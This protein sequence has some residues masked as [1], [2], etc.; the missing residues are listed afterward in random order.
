MAEVRRVEK[1][2]DSNSSF[3]GSMATFEVIGCFRLYKYNI[4]GFKQ[5]IVM[6]LRSDFTTII[7]LKFGYCVRDTC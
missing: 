5:F 6:T 1:E 4:W 3:K 2:L 7:L